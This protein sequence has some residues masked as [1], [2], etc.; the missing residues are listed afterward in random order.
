MEEKKRKKILNAEKKTEARNY[1][2]KERRGA[3][4]GELAACGLP[5]ISGNAPSH[6]LNTQ[7]LN[8]E[9]GEVCGCPLFCTVMT[10]HCVSPDSTRK[11]L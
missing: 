6:V 7:T 9:G 1:R 10:A 3:L 8:I 2:K 4:T 5:W 11:I